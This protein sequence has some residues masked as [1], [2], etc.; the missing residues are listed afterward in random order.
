MRP[1]RTLE[2]C[3]GYKHGPIS[4]GSVCSEGCRLAP[5]PPPVNMGPLSTKMFLCEILLTYGL[6]QIAVASLLVYAHVMP[7]RQIC[8]IGRS[9]CAIGRSLCA[10]ERSLVGADDLQ[11]HDIYQQRC[12]V[13]R[14]YSINHADL[15]NCLHHSSARLNTS[16]RHK[17]LID[18]CAIGR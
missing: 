4:A 13:D 2:G 9:R 16:E 11:R 8:A 17:P 12:A 1:N 15:H 5:P 18:R 6:L 7:Y 14:Q 3:I 10:V